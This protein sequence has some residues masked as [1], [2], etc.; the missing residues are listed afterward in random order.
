MNRQ[1]ATWAAQ[2]DWYI[3]SRY[4]TVLREFKVL[5][6]DHVYDSMTGESIITTRSFINYNELRDW[7][8]Y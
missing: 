1:Q 4:N 2:H 8:G 6:T 3:G 5:V 7:A